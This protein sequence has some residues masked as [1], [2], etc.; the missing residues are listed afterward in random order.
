MFALVLKEI[1]IVG[2]DISDL[3]L[4]I[5]LQ[6]DINPVTCS[7]WKSK[8]ANY[9]FMKICSKANVYASFAIVQYLNF[10]FQEICELP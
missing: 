2:R 6:N 10:L 3:T 8:L 4:S 7:K 5:M 1:F 9:S